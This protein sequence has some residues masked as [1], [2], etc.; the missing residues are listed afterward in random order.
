[1]T[2][3]KQEVKDYEPMPTVKVCYYCMQKE[4]KGTFFKHYNSKITGQDKEG[5]FVCKEHMKEVGGKPL[6]SH[7]KLGDRN[8]YLKYYQEEDKHFPEEWKVMYNQN[9][10]ELFFRKLK[11]RY[12]FNHELKF[13][14]TIQRGKCS[15]Y[16]ISIPNRCSI[17][18]LI[19]EIG[20]AIQY[21]QDHY[22][23]KKG[24][25]F[26]SKKHL[27][28]MKKVFEHWSSNREE[29]IKAEEHKSRNKI[30][31]EENK[32][33]RQQAKKDLKKTNEYKVNHLQQR[34]KRLMTKKKRLET[35]I[36]KIDK[37]LSYYQKKQ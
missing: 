23:Y 16:R 1:V 5:R 6:T 15:L 21:K 24:K 3:M 34:K 35:I 22:V 7:F 33:Q 14:G 10:L 26:H 4:I 32:T 25:R 36:K 31:T 12:K 28:I 30:Q 20:H 19:H 9:D 17:G 27:N 13:Y 29:W 37:S 8:G 2:T 18:L 11:Q